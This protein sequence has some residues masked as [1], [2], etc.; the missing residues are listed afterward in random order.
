MISRILTQADG[1][2]FLIHG[3]EDA[4]NSIQV[5]VDG[6]SSPVPGF[7]LEMATGAAEKLAN[8]L[9][10]Q[11]AEFDTISGEITLEGHSK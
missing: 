6:E 8:N 2:Q 5:T 10:T 9:K 11:T 7:E 3:D 1:S 4:V